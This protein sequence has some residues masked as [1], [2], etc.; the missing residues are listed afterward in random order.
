MTI[1]N[2]ARERQRG[3]RRITLQAELA[4]V[5]ARLNRPRDQ[6]LIARY[7]G[8]DGN[9]PCSLKEAG[10]DFHLTRER[11][12]Q[13]YAEALPVLQQRAP[14]PSLDAVLSFVAKR[15]YELVADV[16]RELL[17]RGFTTGP[18]RL[19]GVLTAAR[20]L[21]RAPAFEVDEFGGAWFVGKVSDPGH[22][23]VNAA[24]K[25]VE[26][27]GASRVSVIREELAGAGRTVNPEFIRRIL[28]TRPDIRW[29]DQ[30]GEWFW[31]TSVPRNR[32]LTRLEKVL[33][34]TRRISLSQL[35]AAISRD[36]KPLRIPDAILRSFCAG[37]DWCRL[38]GREVAAVAELHLEAFLSGAEAIAC[39][40]L[41][42]HGGALPLAELKDRCFKAGVKNANLWRV[43]S[44][45][46]LIR[47][48]DKEI[49]GLV[50]A[51][52]DAVR[53]LR[54]A[55][56]GTGRAGKDACK[57]SIGPRRRPGI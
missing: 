30:T 28:R 10:A 41:R 37:L 56:P 13:V 29:L 48:M 22:L 18:F 3:N 36:Y 31:M 1:G 51:P 5:L 47:R 57:S 38:S 25:Q 14:T 40:I 55:R 35:N 49:Y 16:E 15:Q 9:C 19:Q 12:R 33:A 54:K 23:I 8:W 39:A 4:G 53:R 27:H 34:A 20:L 52:G 42:E 7:L 2:P 26:H 43:L 44:F 17:E 45:S 21:G 11:A 32:L 46:P 50:G 6:K 24:A